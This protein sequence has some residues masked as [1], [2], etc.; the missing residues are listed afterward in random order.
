[1]T[2]TIPVSSTTPR[3]PGT[4]VA[5]LPLLAALAMAASATEWGRRYRTKRN[6]MAL[7]AWQ[8]ADCGIDRPDI[9]SAC[10]MEAAARR[11]N[12]SGMPTDWC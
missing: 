10:D 8:R 4:R 7:S 9:I 5:V 3:R 11:R 2:I 6:L 1:M 12:A